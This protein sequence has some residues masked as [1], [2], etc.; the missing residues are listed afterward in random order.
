MRRLAHRSPAPHPTGKPPLG[1]LV[2]DPGREGPRAAPGGAC[3]NEVAR[4][5]EGENTTCGRTCRE[6]PLY[7][8]GTSK[9]PM[10]S[11][12]RTLMTRAGNGWSHSRYVIRDRHVQTVVGLVALAVSIAVGPMAAGASESG[13]SCMGGGTGA[14][15]SASC[16]R[17]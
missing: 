15:R 8:G 9:V 13:P 14:D 5:H 2:A 4:R 1:S 10:G 6:Q 17:W 7:S 12:E 3:Q 16:T 11:G